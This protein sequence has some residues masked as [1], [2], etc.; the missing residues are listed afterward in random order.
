MTTEEKSEGKYNFKKLKDMSRDELID[1]C[2]HLGELYME[3]MGLKHK[4][5][6]EGFADLCKMALKGI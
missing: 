3:Q 1:A 6:R 5:Q 2:Y 4:A